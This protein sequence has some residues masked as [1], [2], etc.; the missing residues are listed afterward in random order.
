MKSASRCF[1]CEMNIIDSAC[2]IELLAPFT[3]GLSF[4]PLALVRVSYHFAQRDNFV[5][6]PSVYLAYK[7]S[8]SSPV[9]LQSRYARC[10]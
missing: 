6:S 4:F 7:R 8:I 9:R 3:L 5:S 2:V 1:G 10:Y